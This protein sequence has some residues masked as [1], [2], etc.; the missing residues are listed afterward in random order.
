MTRLAAI[1]AFSLIA[2]VAGAQ[3]IARR[4][5]V[6]DAADALSPGDETRLVELLAAIERRTG[7]DVAAVALARAPGGLGALADSLFPR[8]NQGN[9]GLVLPGGEDELYDLRLEYSAKGL[10]LKRR[11]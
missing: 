4:G 7:Y 3:E 2:G 6:T 5:Y 10:S 11:P 1:A 8:W 9:L